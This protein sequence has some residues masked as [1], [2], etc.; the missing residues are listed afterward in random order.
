MRRDLDGVQ[1]GRLGVDLSLQTNALR[2]QTRMT[3][4]ALR[5]AGNRNLMEIGGVWI[6]EA[7]NAKMPV[8]SVKAM[9]TAYF[10]IL[11]RHVMVRDVY[12]LGNDVVWVT[13]SGVAL[14]IDCQ[15]GKDKLDDQEI[16]AL[17]ARK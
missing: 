12:R 3:Q 2:T 9:S 8:V 1:A 6:D 11:E 7:F 16:D 14:V 5:Q 13:P 15:N 17:F 4:T 10:R